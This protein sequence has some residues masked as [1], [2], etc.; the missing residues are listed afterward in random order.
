MG[1]AQAPLFARDARRHREERGRV[2]ARVDALSAALHRAQWG[3]HARVC[4]CQVPWAACH[5]CTA[6]VTEP[7]RP[8]VE[9]DRLLDMVV[10]VVPRVRARELG[11]FVR[12]A[13]LLEVAMEGAVFLQEP[14]LPSAVEPEGGE[15]RAVH[16]CSERIRIVGASARRGAKDT[17]HFLRDLGALDPPPDIERCGVWATALQKSCGYLSASLTAP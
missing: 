15:E 12:D 9:G 6:S 5:P 16:R 7:Q 10:P 14:I 4:T 17:A 1:R 2:S 13:E 3:I 11:V 8:L